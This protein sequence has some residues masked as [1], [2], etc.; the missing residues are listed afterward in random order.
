MARSTGRIPR[1][2][3]HGGWASALRPRCPSCY[4]NYEGTRQP[5][6]LR[7]RL[8]FGAL[9]ISPLTALHESG[10]VPALTLGACMLCRLGDKPRRYDTSN[11]TAATSGTII[12]D[13]LRGSICFAK[14]KAETVISQGIT[15][16]AMRS[17]SRL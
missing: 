13:R 14:L 12:V 15:I 3:Q 5:A 2:E 8:S 11:A 1:T 10:S 4:F 7:S 9:R 17:Q 16:H 6:P